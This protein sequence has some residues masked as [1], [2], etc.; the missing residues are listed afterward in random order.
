MFLINVH[1]QTLSIFL[2]DFLWHLCP[3]VLESNAFLHALWF[4]RLFQKQSASCVQIW[5]GR[6]SWRRGSKWPLAI[7]TKIHFLIS[8]NC[9][10][11]IL[12]VCLNSVK[13]SCR[14]LNLHNWR[15]NPFFAY[16]GR[17]IFPPKREHYPVSF[18]G[19]S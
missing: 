17:Q 7:E 18:W 6:K 9:V 12:L 15:E 11:S 5:K 10:V 8:G 14:Y 4:R 3:L 13:Y 2:K 16:A 1:S 19:L